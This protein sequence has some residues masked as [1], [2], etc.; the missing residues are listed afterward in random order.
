MAEIVFERIK[1]SELCIHRQFRE[2]KKGEKAQQIVQFVCDVAI[3][4]TRIPFCGSSLISTISMIRSKSSSHQVQKSPDPAE[5]P[6][7][8]ETERV[9]KSK[10][11]KKE[12]GYK[13]W[14][15]NWYLLNLSSCPLL[16]CK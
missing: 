5:L 1:N 16:H 8:L 3:R 12:R 4:I 2:K 13:R 9:K 11:R 15:L 14:L 7:G 6:T 10:E